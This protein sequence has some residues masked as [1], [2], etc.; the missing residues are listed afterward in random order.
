MK[1]IIQNGAKQFL[2]LFFLVFLIFRFFRLYV[3]KFK[4]TTFLFLIGD[5]ILQIDH[6]DIIFKKY[7]KEKKKDYIDKRI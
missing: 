1:L 7:I 4:K 3:H 2:L 5:Y 6:I